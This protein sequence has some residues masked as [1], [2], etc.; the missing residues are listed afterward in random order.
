MKTTK[1]FLLLT[2]LCF[3][4]SAEAQFFKKLK[5]RAKDA[6]EETVHQ[7]VE[8][9]SSEKTGEVMDEVL[10]APEEAVKGK[11]KQNG[12]EGSEDSQEYEENADYKDYEE[13]EDNASNG[14]SDP[15]TG[16]LSVYTKFNF[17]PGENILVYDDFSADALGDFPSKWDTNGSGEL[18]THDDS[19]QKWLTLI[20]RSVYLTHQ[21][22][23]PQEYTVEFDLASTGL[24]RKTSSQ[25]YLEVW[26][27]A[28]NDFSRSRDQSFVSIPFCQYTDPGFNI[29]KHTDGKRIIWN[30]V[31]RDIREQILDKTHV[32]IAV[33]KSQIQD[34]GERNQ[35]S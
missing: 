7:K 19:E 32:S 17:V 16:N 14:G 29:S 31:E 25:A 20:N 11:K 10:E 5:Q 3:A 13:S 24:N 22:E 8:Q 28:T 6:A 35:S 33:N 34:V 1:I 26:I 12:E 18:V 30:Q 2:A 9:K 15:G 27:D 4:S 23:L 21:S